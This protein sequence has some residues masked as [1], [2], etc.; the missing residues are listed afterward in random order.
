MTQINDGMQ[1]LVTGMGTDRDKAASVS[2]VADTISPTDLLAAYRGSS[3]ARAIVDKPAVDSCREWRAWQAEDDQITALE[4]EEKRLG[5]QGM[6]LRARKRARLFG[7][8]AIYIGTTDGDLSE[9]LNPERIGAGGIRYLTLLDRMELTPGDIQR[10]PTQ[11]GYGLP[12]WYSI[13]P[14]MGGGSLRIHPSRLAIFHGDELPSNDLIMG[15]DG[16]GDSVLQVAIDKVRHLDSTVANVA[17]LVF[18]AKV[19]VIQIEDFTKNLRELGAKYEEMMLARFAL[20]KLAKGNNGM[21]L[22]DSKEEYSQKSANFSTLPDIVTTFQ[23]MVAQA[24]DIPMSEL[25][26]RTS[27][28]L[29]TG[30]HEA[31]SYHERISRE[32]ALEVGPALSVLDECLIRSALGSRPPEVFYNWR[33]LAKPDAKDQADIATKITSAAKTL[34]EMDALSPEALTKATV[35]ALTESGA[36]PGLEAA[37]SEFPQLGDPMEGDDE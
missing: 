27:G 22:L 20:A 15:G 13:T 18:E 29:N 3:V 6:V 32:Q 25:F 34:Y 28:G 11:P 19:D 7:G 5:L 16:W 26:E 4:A 35:N 17:S 12:A 1:S 23:V 24:A 8:S 14:A 31:D 37:V 2:Y 21:L 10:D 9:P 33:P 30:G 36:F